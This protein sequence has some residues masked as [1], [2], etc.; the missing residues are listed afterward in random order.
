[1][2]KSFKTKKPTY[3]E[4]AEKLGVSVSAINQYNKVKRKLM[5]LG[6][7]IEKESRY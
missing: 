1:M 6:L 7:W 3:K 2:I 4:L 5:I